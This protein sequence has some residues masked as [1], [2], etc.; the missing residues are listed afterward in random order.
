MNT[1]LYG[2]TAISKAIRER[3]FEEDTTEDELVGLATQLGECEERI[4]D[5]V[6]AYRSLIARFTNEAEFH[7]SEAARIATRA[8][9]LETS[10][11][12]LEQH[13]ANLLL[14]D[15]KTK[16]DLPTATVVIRAN[17]RVVALVTPKDMPDQFVTLG[18][19]PRNVNKTAL[20]E[21]LEAGQAEGFA[22][23]EHG[24]TIA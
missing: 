1:S 5:K 21:A 20:R 14:D 12:R 6:D 15:G 10:A 19:A 7:K 4:E 23:F 24:V 9:K 2:L 22:K 16:V 8:K 3:M 13:M 11:S 17:S 18:T